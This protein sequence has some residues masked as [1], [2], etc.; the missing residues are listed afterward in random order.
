MQLN[1]V[2]CAKCINEIVSNNEEL[3]MPMIIIHVWV[4]VISVSHFNVEIRR[5][6]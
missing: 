5:I 3:R 2:V 4:F 1:I 6:Y